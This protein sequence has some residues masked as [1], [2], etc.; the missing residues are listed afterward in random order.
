[1]PSPTFSLRRLVFRPAGAGLALC[2]L[3]LSSSAFAAA[4]FKAE[5]LQPRRAPVGATLFTALT[6]EQTGITHVNTY[7]DPRMWN[8]LFREFT[9][10]A[11]GTGVT[12]GDY[13]SDGRPDIF[14][15]NKTSPCRLY[16]QVGDLVFE[17]VTEKA[18]LMPEDPKA[19]N[20][21]ATF[22][23]VNGNGRLD[24]YVSRFNAPN[25]LF[26][27]QG[28][29]T[30]KEG[31]AAA[32][33]AIKDASVMASF[34]DYDRDGHLDFYLQTNILSYAANF[35][36]R[37]DYLFRNNGDGTFT[38]V[39][40]EAGIWGLSQGHSA[41]WWDFDDDGWPDIYVANDFENPD[42]LYRNNG[43]GTFT[44][45][46]ETL[47]PH[48]SYSSMGS[49]LGDINNDGRT[50]FI[51][52]DMAATNHYKDHIGIEEMGRGI[53]EGEMAR[54][55]SPQYPFNA[56][57]LN[58]GTGRFL[59]IA[60]LA[61]LRATDWTW[62]AR[63]ADLDNDGWL[64]FHVCTGMVRD[65][66]DADL[67]D[68]QNVAATLAQRAA[69]YVNAPPRAEPDLAYRNL[70]DLRFQEVGQA[71]GLGQTSVSFGAA[72]ADL[73]RDGDLD[74]VVTNYEAPPTI[75]RND[76]Q[77]GHR[78]LIRLVGQGAN[79]FGVGAVVRIE[80]DA[81]IQIR[82]HT[83]TRGIASSDEPLIHFGLGDQAVIGRL[84]VEW[85]SGRHQL[86]TDVKAD[87]FL[88]ITEPSDPVAPPPKPT[89]RAQGPSPLRPSEPA[90]TLFTEVSRASGLEYV[91]Q[92]SEVNEFTRQI[93]LPRRLGAFGPGI[94]V[95]D[96]TGD[97]R[98]EVLLPGAMFV[99]EAPGRF[100]RRELPVAVPQARAALAPFLVDAT[101][102]GR[103]DLLVVR[104]G[105]G[106][107]AGDFGLL[108]E[109]YLQKDD[110][111]WEPA[112]DGALAPNRDSSG[113]VVAADF[114]GDGQ[115]D[116][117]IGGR[118]VPHRYPDVPQSRLLRNVDGT[119][120]DV[121]DEW[122][123]GLRDVGLVTSALWSDVDGDGRPDLLVTIE[124]GPVM[125]WRNTG[126]SLEDATVAM[127]LAGRTGWWTSIAAA[128][129]NGDGRM[130]YVVGNVGLNTK[131]TASPEYPAVLFAGDLDGSGRL[132]VVE[133]RW[134]DDRL[135]PVRGRSKSAYAMPFIRRKY[136]TF[137]AWARATVQDIFGEERLAA[138]RRL[139]ATELA[140]GVLLN[141]GDRFDFVA[142]PTLAQ[143]APA[144]GLALHDFD[145]DG[146][147]D[148]AMA[149][150]FYG[151]E[152]KTGRFDGGISLLL[153]GDGRGGF[154]A[155]EPVE[156]GIVVPGDAKAL[157]VLDL[158]GNGR[159][160]LLVSQHA[161][162]LL[163]FEHGGVAGREFFS[164]A[165]QGRPG[166]P[167][168][169]GGRIAVRYSDG[170]VETRELHAGA[171]HL[172]QSVPRAFF[173]Y[174]PENPPV[175]LTVRWP[176]GPETKQTWS[177][178]KGPLVVIRR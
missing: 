176:D 121:T 70:G 170:H 30:F 169:I 124:W 9:L 172:S 146:F 14:V 111:T 60:H 117:F 27:N 147:V 19:W 126:K 43:D 7:D 79:S 40:K 67:L 33:I 120:V 62:S 97:G 72:F 34:A 99:A 11:V 21:G 174:R 44:D 115:L 46:S 92:E 123:P 145:G 132:N 122:A 119:F 42:R 26:L 74:I 164:V 103:Q 98:D 165:L 50:D 106:R 139:E 24:I 95:G 93:L 127:G 150:N 163:A 149:Q 161:G 56:L 110:G 73:D 65:F 158:Q 48:T 151:P 32:G 41:V 113:T 142:L 137:D 8:E 160:D 178:V 86:F 105:V 16:R 116:L 166:N 39:T 68:K 1:M 82:Q 100:S 173:G 52:T 135:Y 22:V 36:G 88:T 101:G 83:L 37:P 157:A 104:G 125:V 49:D 23:D 63:F 51:V 10:G 96:V 57:Y 29:G 71:W 153:R 156:S 64:D 59:E 167:H 31:A 45:V 140:S 78:L 38:D 76:S 144:F 90:R 69:V 5:P 171:G 107:P 18:G 148:L 131:Y 2:G 80:T 13:D 177:Q 108:D 4:G 47:L 141:R 175:E 12:I 128:D 84:S 154:T 159:P 35:K 102:N 75:F 143:V 89:G 130:D 152:P 25:L 28:D 81:G 109:L 114:D 3:A 53:W 155:V 15:V 91:G 129:V 17:D 136:R 133:A 94:A 87:Q 55:L 168:A 20:T 6:P 134:E 138:A 162:R 77:T 112:A 61:G 118:V 66:M 85:P 54:A 58:N